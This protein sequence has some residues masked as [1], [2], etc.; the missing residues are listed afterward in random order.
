LRHHYTLA[1]ALMSLDD[2][3]RHLPPMHLVARDTA[4][5]A[6][7]W[8]VWKSQNRMVSDAD[9]LPTPRILAPIDDHFMLWVVRAPRHVD[10]AP[11]VVW[12][13]SVLPLV[14]GS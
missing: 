10:T 14:M 11:L 13:D 3:L 1:P 9:L 2:L 6:I 4:A 7:L 12:C 8:S 5:L